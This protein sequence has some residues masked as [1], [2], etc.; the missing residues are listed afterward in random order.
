MRSTASRGRN[1][2]RKEDT[3]FRQISFARE[4]SWEETSTRE[5]KKRRKRRDTCCAH[6]Y[7]RVYTYRRRD[8]QS[9]EPRRGAII[10][11]A[12]AKRKEARAISR[13]REPKANKEERCPRL[14]GWCCSLSRSG[15]SSNLVQRGLRRR[16]SRLTRCQ[17][18][19]HGE[20]LDGR[21][22]GGEVV[23]KLRYEELDAR[24]RG[25]ER[26]KKKT[27]KKRKRTNQK[28]EEEKRRRRRKTKRWLRGC[29]CGLEA[30][31]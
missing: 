12:C 25:T 10:D 2:S 29:Q 1:R 28:G 18:R 20:G 27:R 23:I 19:F 9:E 15:K 30:C 22:P 24:R 6:T 17:P 8:G 21:R 14:Q 16:R 26:T 11:P 31:Q 4:R 5:R 7:A 13:S 3:R